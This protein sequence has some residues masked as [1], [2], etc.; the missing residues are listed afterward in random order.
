MVQIP[1]VPIRRRKLTAGGG[2]EFSW[3]TQE[4]LI[5]NF[6]NSIAAISSIALPVASL[7]V[8]CS[9]FLAI[10][11]RDPTLSALPLLLLRR[12]ISTQTFVAV[13]TDDNNL[14]DEISPSTL[15]HCDEGVTVTLISC[16][17]TC[18]SSVYCTV[19]FNLDNKL[20]L[21]L[22]WVV[23]ATADINMPME[24]G[25]D[26]TVNQSYNVEVM[27]DNESPMEGG[28]NTVSSNSYNVEPML[29]PRFPMEAG[30][31]TDG[32]QGINVG[33]EDVIAEENEEDEELPEDPDFRESDEEVEDE[34]DD[35]F[36]S[37][38]DS[39][40]Y[41]SELR[42]W[43]GRELGGRDHDMSD[44]E[45]EYD[46][47]EILRSLSDSSDS[48]VGVQRKK[49]CKYPRFNEETDLQGLG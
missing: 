44:E 8:V 27:A 36:F 22:N 49:R 26:A 40:A 43:L 31:D 30:E 46:N 38:A 42:A 11:H 35:L 48:D 39:D 18:I 7:D 16:H 14:I 1:V 19:L 21:H 12:T 10:C 23:E 34:E 4:E 47:T 3:L 24:G 15:A 29:E 9:D 33:G 45:S 32:S 37:T 6:L 20:L 41:E 2:R 13:I 25:K 17:D 5:R 28:E